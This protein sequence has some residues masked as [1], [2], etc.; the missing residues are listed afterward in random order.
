MSKKVWSP[1]LFVL[2]GFLA[3]VGAL[4]YNW[5]QKLD[6]QLEESN[7]LHEARM[8]ADAESFAERIR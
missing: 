5:Q 4:Y 8:K 1:V 3:F 2:L 7:R 6:K